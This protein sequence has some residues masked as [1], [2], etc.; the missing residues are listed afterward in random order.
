MAYARF[1]LA[2]FAIV[3]VSCLTSAY[4][5]LNA[6]PF[7]FDMFVKPQL[8]PWLTTFVSWHHLWFALAYVLSLGTLSQ[9]LR[10]RPPDGR[11]SRLARVLAIGY[12]GCMGFIALALVSSPFLPTL[13]NDWRALPTAVAALIPLMW[14]AAIDHVSAGSAT[15]PGPDVTTGQRRLLLTCGGTALYLWLIH[16]ARA[17]AHSTDGAGGGAWILTGAWTMLLTATFFALVFAA[18]SLLTAAAARTS[19]PRGAEHALLVALAATGISELFRRAVLP[20]LSLAPAHC[21]LIGAATGIAAALSW[22]GL[23]LRRPGVRAGR[24][25]LASEVLL[26]S[27]SPVSA[28]AASFVMLSVL[29][30]VVLARIERLDWNFVAQR[31][32]LI[33]EGAAAFALMLRLTAGVREGAGRERRLIVI[34]A[35]VL[36]IFLATP[37]T[38][39]LIAARSGDRSIASATLLERHAAAEIAFRLIADALVARPGAVDPDYQRRLLEHAAASA[40]VSVPSIDFPEPVSRAHDRSRPDIFLFVVDSLRRDYLSAYNPRVTFTTS[41]GG[42]AAENF[43]FRNAFTRHGGTELAMASIWSGATAVRKV[44]VNGFERMNALEKLVNANGYRIAINDFTIAEHLLKTTEKTTIDPGVPSVATDLCRN[45]QSLQEHLDA[46]AQDPRPV[47][48][49]FA[50]M[51][52]HI[53]NTQRG[54]QSSLDG[55]YPGFYAPYASRV[56][57]L[58]ACFGGFI[59]YL[60]ARGRYDNSI[61]VL[62]SDHGDSLGEEGHWGHATWLFPE[63]VRVPLIVRIPE[64]VRPAMTTD[65]ARVAFSSDIAPTLHV[66]LGQPVRDLGPLFGS[67]LFVPAAAAPV[68]RRRESFLL[69]SSYGATF[70]L[71]RRNGSRLYVSDLNDW[72]ESAYDLTHGVVGT[73]AEIDPAVRRRDQRRIRELVDEVAELYGAPR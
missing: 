21:A 61:I 19:R 16:V 24:I 26:P 13:W 34:P 25:R 18:L 44:R 7:A 14:L 60:K 46:S 38:V 31:L 4:A 36:A 73:A 63:D 28:V 27:A 29:T 33:A 11:V 15:M 71:L 53:L 52:V 5:V 59:A 20:T 48:G 57:R 22:S 72:R 12:A 65:L 68:D 3:A 58:D 30:L 35:A 56:K 37:F 39:S 2:R 32:V 23:M 62:T 1:V 45:L 50:P 51:N 69:T 41:I 70:G 40:P 17:F 10:A 66:L 42:F 55:D 49:F 47:L 9:E 8:F 54:G 6:S 43:V 64:S 67:P